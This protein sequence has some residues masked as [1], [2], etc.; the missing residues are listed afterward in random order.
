MHEHKCIISS[1]DLVIYDIHF[2][3]FRKNQPSEVS[4]NETLAL[5]RKL[6]TRRMVMNVGLMKRHVAPPRCTLMDIFEGEYHPL[7]PPSGPSCP[8]AILFWAKW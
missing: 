7:F 4:F 3:I 1:K 2:M 6:T 5:E 8:T